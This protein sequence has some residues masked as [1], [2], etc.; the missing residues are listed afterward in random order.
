LLWS[1]VGL[2]EVEIIAL[3]RR[4]GGKYLNVFSVESRIKYSIVQYT[5]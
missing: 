4:F 3:Y 2:L 5:K 1:L